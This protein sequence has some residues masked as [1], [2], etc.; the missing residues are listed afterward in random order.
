MRDAYTLRARPMWRKIWEFPLV[1]MLVALAVLALAIGVPA[2]L[3]TFVSLPLGETGAIIFN[4]VLASGLAILA[5]KLVVSR[6]G[7]EP[8][9]DLA[10][11][12]AARWLLIGT[13]VAA[14]LMTAIVGFVALLGGYRISGWGGMESWAMIL[15][16]GGLQ[17]AVI[18]EILFRGI[19]F[20]FLE[21]FGGSW[22]ALT[23]T[24]AL[25]GGA[26]LM[27]ENASWFS[28]LAI[29]VEAGILLGAAYMAVRSLW[30]PIGLHFGW[31]VTQGLVW[32][33]PVSGHQVDGM[34]ASHPAGSEIVSGGMFGV[35]ASVV[36]LVL[37][38]F[39]GLYFVWLGVQRNEI[40]RP[41]WVRRKRD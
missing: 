30:L 8:G 20:R 33:V 34:V 17:A 4:G 13:V 38:T 24:S 1:A 39:I 3:L 26:H 27:N 21:Q 25:F 28:S 12:D 32:D 22:F 29:A 11:K 7:E 40:L 10:W 41:W 18:E 19:L 23:L 37:A 16:L 15:F 6:L 31:N 14:F 2:Y 36:A 35:E 9:D 5:Y